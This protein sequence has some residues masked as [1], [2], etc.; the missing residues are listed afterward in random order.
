MGLTV[1]SE[2]FLIT[3]TARRRELVPT[4]AFDFIES[5]VVPS[6]EI[7][8][9]FTVS[10]LGIQAKTSLDSSVNVNITATVITR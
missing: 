7:K 9:S 4:I 10:L 3:W 1:T 5:K 8:T 6:E 2:R